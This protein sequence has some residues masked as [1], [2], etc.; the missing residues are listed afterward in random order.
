M[1]IFISSLATLNFISFHFGVWLI[2]SKRLP[3]E[4]FEDIYRVLLAVVFA[5]SQAGQSSGFAPDFGEAK[6]SAAKIIQ[7]FRRK[8]KIQDGPEC[9]DFEGHVTLDQVLFRQSWLFI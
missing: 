8:S 6:I 5:A 4:R 1:F 2:Q 7:F 3:A 9:I